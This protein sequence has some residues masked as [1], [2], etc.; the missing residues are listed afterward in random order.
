MTTPRQKTGQYG[1][2]LAANYLQAQGYRII[3]RNWRC[4]VGEIDIVA[5][6]S[7]EWVFVEVRTRH[8]QNTDSAAESIT[9]SKEAH[10]INAAEAYVEAH[11]LEETPW[12]I[13]LVMVALTKQGPKIEVIHDAVGW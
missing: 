12:R 9:P 10:I 5:H 6:D 4:K 8:A 13:D 1:E 11:A 3:S 2:D 7:T